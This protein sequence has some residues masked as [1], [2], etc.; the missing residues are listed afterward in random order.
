MID[1][2]ETVNTHEKKQNK[3]KKLH[4]YTDEYK[5][6]KCT[7]NTEFKHTNKTNK[8]RTTSSPTGNKH[9][10]KDK[11]TNCTYKRNTITKYFTV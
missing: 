11:I 4:V 9:K 5:Y 7:V 1:W 10:R 3:T 8:Y 2:D 6:V